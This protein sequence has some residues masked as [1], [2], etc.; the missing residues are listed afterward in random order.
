MTDDELRAAVIPNPCKAMQDG[1]DF[2]VHDMSGKLVACRTA[3]FPVP[4]D[5][6]IAMKARAWF[7]DGPAKDVAIIWE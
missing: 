6:T 4:F 5:L 7:I 1:G 3:P 2:Y